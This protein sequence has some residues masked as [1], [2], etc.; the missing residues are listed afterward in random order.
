MPD[1]R[2]MSRA[3]SAVSAGFVFGPEQGRARVGAERAN[4]GCF[5]RLNWRC[6]CVRQPPFA[7]HRPRSVL[8]QDTV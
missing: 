8:G 5:T 4:K 6:P 2:C 1:T 7:G 3:A